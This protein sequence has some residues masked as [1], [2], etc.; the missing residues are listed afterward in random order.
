[1]KSKLSILEYQSLDYGLREINI[2]FNVL[3]INT[4]YNQAVIEIPNQFYK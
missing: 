2:S 4:H 3:I 1:M